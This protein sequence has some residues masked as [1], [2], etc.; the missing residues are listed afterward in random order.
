[1]TAPDLAGLRHGKREATLADTAGLTLKSFAA[2]LPC[3]TLR[4]LIAARSRCRHEIACGLRIWRGHGAAFRAEKEDANI[5]AI[6]ARNTRARHPKLS[7]QQRGTILYVV[8]PADVPVAAGDRTHV[9]EDRV[10]AE[11]LSTGG[12]NGTSCSVV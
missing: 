12:H 4:V 2:E 1:M 10:V 7:L 11:S 6:L 9:G 8:A 5:H 3:R